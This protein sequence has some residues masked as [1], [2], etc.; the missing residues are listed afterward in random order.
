MAFWAR[1]QQL[2][3][4]GLLLA[5]GACGGGGSTTPDT[6]PPAFLAG[7]ELTTDA[8][9]D[10][11]PTWIMASFSSRVQLA[12]ADFFVIG[13]TCAHLPSQ[14]TVLDASK[15][16]ITI[17]LSG[18]SCEPGQ[19]IVLTLNPFK[20]VL[21]N[22][23]LANA[24]IWTRTFTIV[25]ASQKIG[26]SVSGLTGSVGLKNNNGETLVVSGNGAFSFPALVNAGQPYSVTVASQPT[27]QTCSVS[28]G[29]GT[30]GTNAVSNVAV[31]CAVDSFKVSGTV[32]GLSGTLELLNNGGDAVTMAAN[33][34]F[35]FPTPVAFGA[36][37]A[38]TVRSKPA[39]QTCTVSSGS[40]TMGSGP[41]SNVV[42]VCSVN[43]YT[44]SGT[45]S[46]LVGTLSVRNNGGPVLAISAD[47]AFSFPAPVAFGSPY[48]VTVSTQPLN[49]T[50]VLTNATGTMG[51]AN[52]SNVAVVCSV[53]TFTVSGTVSGLVG[54]LNLSNNG[55]DALVVNANGSFTFPT[56]V[57]VGS[58]YAVTVSTQPLNQTCTVTN[59]TGTMGAANVTN[60]AVACAATLFSAGNTYTGTAGAGDV[61]SG[62]IAGLSG[63]TFNGD[64]AD[65]DTI[66][67]TTAGTANIN[68]GSTGGTMTNIKTLTLA[69]GT[70]TI[71]FANGASGIATVAG[72]T[73]DDAVDLTNTGNSFLAGTVTL[74]AGNNSLTLENKT[75][76][77]TFTAGAGVSD[78][79]YLASGSNTSGA[80]VTGFENLSLPSG[81]TVT[82]AAAQTGQFAGSTGTAPGTETI[83]L[84][85]AGPVSA[86][87]GIEVYNLANGTNNFTSTN[88]AV[89][90]VG[91]TGADT[92]N[93]TANQIVNFLTSLNGGGGANTL[94]IGATTTQTIDLTTGNKIQNIQTVNVAGSTGTA[95]FTNL[96]GAG[97]VLNY[98]K[99]TGANT[100]NLGSGGQTLNLTGGSNAATTIT[101]SSSPD[102]ISLQ[103]SGGASET[104]IE[105]GANMSNKTSIDKVSNFSASGVDFFKTGVQAT[106]VGSFV[107]GNADTGNYLTSIASGLSIVL[108]NTGQSYL[109]TIQTGTAAGTYLFQNTGSDTSQFDNTDFFVQLTGAFGAIS[110]VNMIP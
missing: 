21:E 29:T 50:C 76:T 4:L 101:G 59:G 82:M 86:I 53:N 30:V 35:S 51:A 8:Q 33:G 106:T 20:V 85:T 13:G 16:V 64:A 45:V 81:A 68:N 52:V 61:F 3:L 109:I 22:A 62:P 60:V 38:V 63:S 94:N 108:N 69:N 77:G 2:T 44:V 58:T 107:I 105:T 12:P 42:V 104:L 15:K 91:V 11:P 31:V 27:G 65:T 70:N 32:S 5:L 93:F 88:V 57:A 110:T 87:P 39:G 18:A 100:I 34:I 71:T 26:G 1:L 24:Q 47:G 48:A 92:F 10:T 75:Y 43:S 72:G 89:I 7:V 79:L 28:Q 98:T 103:S 99:S 73:G 66:T 25:A 23:T 19:T 67:L 84:A 14:T 90:V 96:D 102:T 97:L 80:T 55:V 56:S 54:T 46:G 36:A 17:N 78:T 95:S 74:G 41:V 6:P 83:N 9:G 37:Y 40:G 49:Q